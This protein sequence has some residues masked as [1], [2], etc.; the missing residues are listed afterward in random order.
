MLARGADLQ[1]D[2]PGGIE[3]LEGRLVVEL[4]RVAEIGEKRRQEPLLAPRAALQQRVHGEL[5]RIADPPPVLEHQL[6]IGV[7]DLVEIE[8]PLVEVGDLARV[9]LAVGGALLDIA[10]VEA[11]DD[12][13]DQRRRLTADVALAVHQKLIQKCQR[14]HLLR[15]VQ[16]E[17]VRLKNAQIRAQAAPVHLAARQLQQL[18]EAP[19]P[20]QTVHQFDVVPHALQHQRLQRL[21][22]RQQRDG[23]FR[24]RCPVGPAERD[25][26]A[27]GNHELLKIAQAGVDPRIAQAL[28]LVH[29]VELRENHV[30]RFGERGDV[31]DLLTVRA[32]RLLHAEVRVDQQQRLHGQ[33]IRLQIPHGMV[34]RD[35]TDV[36]DA[37][38]AEPEV[39]VVIVQIRHALAGAAAELADVVP[40]R[41]AGD[42]RKV[43]RH[44]GL[45]QRAS[46]RHRD[47]VDARDVL[48]R[49]VGRR[50]QPEAHHL[51]DVLAPP[52]ARHLAVARGAGAALQLALRQERDV[53]RR[54]V[55]HKIPL[56][57]EEYLQNRQQKRRARPVRPDG[58]LLRE[59]QAARKIVGV[60]QPAALRLAGAEHVQLRTAQCQHVGAADAPPS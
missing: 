50:F 5:E 6:V 3:Q 8:L 16:I 12:L 22:V 30:K 14:L 2:R 54:I 26:H 39:G 10:L 46:R 34:R 9:G 24:L 17:G 37:P 48:E 55:R 47:V 35:V 7:D 60:E 15:N 44:A 40:R 20:G 52:Q 28:G 38:A 11:R 19:L 18:R 43:H 23:L 58:A 21:L 27:A 59:Q 49:A 41:R 1:P 33:V 32:A 36:R 13:A 57:G 29:T 51:I 56:G 45:L 25:V 31:G 42:E 4:L 53:P